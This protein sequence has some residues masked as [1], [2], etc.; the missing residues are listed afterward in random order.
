MALAAAEPSAAVVDRDQRDQDEIGL[1]H[2]VA[3]GRLHDPERT[4]LE[5]VAGEEAER[6]GGIVKAREGDDRADRARFLHRRQRADLATRA[7]A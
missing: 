4:G 7:G 6:L 1:D 3:L 2:R 5:R